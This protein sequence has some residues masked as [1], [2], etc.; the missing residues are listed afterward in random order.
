MKTIQHIRQSAI[1]VLLPL[2]L[3]TISLTSVK[4]SHIVG[5]EVTYEWQS[6]NVYRVKLALYRDCQGAPFSSSAII[7]FSSASLSFSSTLPLIPVGVPVEITPICTASLPNSFCNGGNLLYGVQKQVYEGVITLTAPASDWVFSYTDC[8]RNAAP[9]NIV[10]PN[11]Y[12]SYFEATLD[13]LNTPFNNSVQ[14]AA[15]PVNILYK[16][17]T[18]LLNWSAWDPDM[19]SLVFD[20]VPPRASA[21]GNLPYATGYTALQPIGASQP[22]ILNS[23][24]GILEVTPNA[25]QTNIVCIRVSEYR[26]GILISTVYRDLQITVV[27]ATNTLPTLTGM[28]GP[29][30]YSTTACPGDTVSFTI[31]SFDP[32]LGQ[33]LTLTMDQNPA[34]AATFTS[35]GSPPVGTFQWIPGPGDIS[36]QPYVFTIKVDDDFCDYFGTQTYAY[37][38][39]VNGCASYDVWPGDANSDG[40]ADL[41]DLLALG[42]AFNDNGPVRPSASLNW[43][44][45]PCPDWTNS[46]TSGINHKHADCDGNGT[47]DFADT[48]AIIQNYGLNHPLRLMPLSMV[49]IPDLIVTS[50]TDTVGTSTQMYFDISLGTPSAPADSIYGLAF[51][52][53]YDPSLID[54]NSVSVTYPG[55]MFG[56]N[57]TDMVTVNRNWSTPGYVDIALSRINQLNL[58][59]NGPVARVTVVTTDNVSGKVTLYATPADVEA[60]S[61]MGAPITINPIGD[62]VIIDPF[63]TGIANPDALQFSIR[64]VPVHERLYITF[65][66]TLPDEMVV[67]DLAGRVVMHFKPESQSES[68]QVNLL[69]PGAYMLKAVNQ[70]AIGVKKFL[71]Y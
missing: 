64:P 40:N 50:S 57:G 3:L 45:Q 6:G 1:R 26:S 34:P 65:G 67:T 55:C 11:I 7:Q 70:N 2:L 12:G 66:E 38:I 36:S 56:T 37:S 52:L 15:V 8:C 10:N 13:N 62:S 46:F 31:N 39:F 19:D 68:I 61:A 32:D 28:G 29:T 63:L 59:G 58:A 30:Q 54:T 49:G 24:T 14:F 42:L 44:A 47:V 27:N 21:T 35:A 71:V 20:L 25:L 53:Y 4:A 18:T 51:R 60:V 69:T 43:T 33:S 17:S 23:A 41:Y 48:S 5:G 22:T 16:N 9:V